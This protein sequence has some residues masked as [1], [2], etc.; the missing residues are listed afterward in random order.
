M[1]KTIRLVLPEDFS[2]SLEQHKAISYLT[3]W[4]NATKVEIY[5]HKDLDMTAHYYRGDKHYFTIGAIQSEDHTYS[6][7]S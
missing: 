3:L 5:V 4:G 1:E 7:H 2:P 6:F